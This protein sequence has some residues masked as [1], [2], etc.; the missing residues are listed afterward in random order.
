LMNMLDVNVGLVASLSVWFI[1]Q[2]GIA[3]RT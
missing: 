1:I 2:L 3:S